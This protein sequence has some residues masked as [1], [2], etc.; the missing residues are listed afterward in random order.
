MKGLALSA[1]FWEQFVESQKRKNTVLH[2]IILFNQA[3]ITHL[4]SILGDECFGLGVKT[5]DA[6]WSRQTV[7]LEHAGPVSLGL[8]K[9]TVRLNSSAIIACFND[10]SKTQIWASNSIVSLK[11][12]P[13]IWYSK[14]YYGQTRQN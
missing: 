2:Q 14:E 9:I 5:F 10:W 6:D 1:E 11:C 3:S 13:Y 7:K 8:E 12:Q 4:I